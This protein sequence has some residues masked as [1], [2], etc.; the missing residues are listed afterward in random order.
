[1]D[2]LPYKQQAESDKLYI[3]RNSSGIEVAFTACGAKLVYLK[4]PDKNGSPTSIVLSS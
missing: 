1:M 4:V 3:M 2:R